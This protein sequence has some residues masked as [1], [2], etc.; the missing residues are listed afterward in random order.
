[1]GIL[2][3]DEKLQNRKHLGYKVIGKIADV[4]KFHPDEF[5]AVIVCIGAVNDTLNRTKVYEYLKLNNITVT[6]IISK[7]AQIS[8]DVI[9]NSGLIAMHGVI[10]NPGCIIDENVF[11]NTGCIIDHDCKINNNVFVSPGAVL[12]GRVSIKSNSFIGAG[13]VISTD[14]YI[15]EN[16][17]IGA[18]SVV[19]KDVPDNVIVYGNPAHKNL[20]K[21]L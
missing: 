17:T 16:V 3:D 14:L 11:L 9:I 4:T 8:S 1:M 7:N 12:S 20:K 18:G 15:G 6:P 21:K 13:S 5:D 2:D 10:V 19:V